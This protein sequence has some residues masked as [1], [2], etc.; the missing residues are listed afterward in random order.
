M[1]RRAALACALLWPATSQLPP[2]LAAWTLTALPCRFFLQGGNPGDLT[3][4]KEAVLDMQRRKC[5][6]C[7]AVDFGFGMT[8]GVQTGENS[9]HASLFLVVSDDNTARPSTRLPASRR[10]PA[11][12]SDS[13]R[14]PPQRAMLLAAFTNLLAQLQELPRRLPRSHFPHGRR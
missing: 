5:G 7:I 4:R 9:S 12:T 3:E 8:K 14:T 11:G 6:D 13:Q 1:G 2:R 10:Q